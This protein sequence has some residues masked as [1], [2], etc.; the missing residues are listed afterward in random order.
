MTALPAAAGAAAEKRPAAGRDAPVVPIPDRPCP[1]VSAR[2]R[3]RAAA[4]A[5]AADDARCLGASERRRSCGR[6]RR[7]RGRGSNDRPVHSSLRELCRPA[8][9]VQMARIGRLPRWSKNHR[10][11]HGQK[12]GLDWPAAVAAS[13]AD[14]HAEVRRTICRPALTGE[15]SGAAAIMKIAPVV[16]RSPLR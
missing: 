6:P 11:R 10:L 4:S 14:G 9:R 3:P 1:S 13:E 2:G 15:S 12:S 8:E 7:A 5:G 16:A